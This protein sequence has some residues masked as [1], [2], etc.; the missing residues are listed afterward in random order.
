[1]FVLFVTIKWRDRERERKREREKL[2]KAICHKKVIVEMTGKPEVAIKHYVF[3]II[4][5]P[6]VIVYGTTVHAASLALF[7]YIAR[8]EKKYSV[9]LNSEHSNYGKI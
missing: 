8:P 6:V 1:M 5:L 4:H 3:L 9:N 7:A 2:F